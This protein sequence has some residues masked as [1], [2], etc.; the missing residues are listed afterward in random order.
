[1]ASAHFLAKAEI[2]DFGDA[3]VE[4]DV[5]RLQVV[6]DDFGL[7]GV[8]LV[9]VLEP[10]EH[11]PDDGLGF[12][13]AQYF[14]DFEILAQVRAVALLEDCAKGVVVDLAGSVLLD[15]VGVLQLLVDLAS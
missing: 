4:N 2:G 12:L 7:G 9:E 14:V 10:R 13:L 6:V 5:L 8:L 11:L 15:D 1:M 3:L